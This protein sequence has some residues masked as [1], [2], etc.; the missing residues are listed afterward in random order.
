MTVDRGD[1]FIAA[2]WDL[3][4]DKNPHGWTHGRRPDE[5]FGLSLRDTHTATR[6]VLCGPQSLSRRSPRRDRERAGDFTVSS[7]VLVGPV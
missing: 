4:I 3:T 2:N 1:S 6:P 7:R 5:Y